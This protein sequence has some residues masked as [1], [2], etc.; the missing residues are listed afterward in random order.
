[1]GKPIV[2]KDTMVGT[3]A[4]NAGL[5]GRCIGA[6]KAEYPAPRPCSRFRSSSGIPP[7]FGFPIHKVGAAQLT[8][9]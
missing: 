8:Q 1:M 7:Q 2:Q 6:L 3:H 5:N 9:S 4:V